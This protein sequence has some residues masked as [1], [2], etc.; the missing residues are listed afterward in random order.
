[1]ARNNY[2]NTNIYTDDTMYTPTSPVQDGY[3]PTSPV[4][5]G[6]TELISEKETSTVTQIDEVL[7]DN[8]VPQTVG[9][10]I[11]VKGKAK[12]KDFHLHN[13]WNY[14]GRSSKSDVHIDDPKVS[15]TMARVSYD[16]R[17]RA[18]AISTSEGAKNLT[19]C[20]GKAVYNTVEI[21]AYDTISMGDTDF[22]FVPLCGSHFNWEE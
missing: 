2:S 9:W 14:I 20:N 18:F 6:K 19:Y 8:E 7:T 1:M 17:N 13:G 15:S 16:A 22:I 11:C 21:N 5:D 4:E 12:G 10:L 3:N